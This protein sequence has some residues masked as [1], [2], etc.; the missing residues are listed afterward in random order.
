M[1]PQSHPTVYQRVAADKLSLL[2]QAVSEVFQVLVPSVASSVSVLGS[3]QV[4][5]AA[6]TTLTDV[7]SISTTLT[8]AVDGVANTARN[9]TADEIAGALNGVAA[10]VSALTSA[11]GRR[12]LKDDIT[13][14]G[15][16]GSS[17]HL[18]QSTVSPP[19]HAFASVLAP[20]MAGSWCT[21][22]QT[23]SGTLMLWCWTLLCQEFGCE[24]SG[25]KQSCCT[26]HTANSWLRGITACTMPWLAG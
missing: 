14:S 3:T 18:L 6:N 16:A 17:R 10:S 13:A 9:G 12:L 22:L 4:S 23:W 25:H 21:C 20:G 19:L 5:Q 26:C 8:S 1:K 7:Q 15:L 2:V 11:F 24:V